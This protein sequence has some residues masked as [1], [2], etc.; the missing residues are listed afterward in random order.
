M[1]DIGIELTMSLIQI[2]TYITLLAFIPDG[3]E[4]PLA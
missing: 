1:S 3:D 4:V 2:T